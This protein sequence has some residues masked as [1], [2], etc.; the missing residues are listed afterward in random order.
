MS[1]HATPS[2]VYSI[3]LIA[4]SM[5]A[6]VSLF[7]V[8]SSAKSSSPSS[9]SSSAEAKALLNSDWWGNFS[10]TNHCDL[11]GIVCNGA[12]SVIRMEPFLSY[13]NR[14]LENMNWSSLPNLEYIDLSD[15]G[16]TGGIPNEI[17]TL[18]KLTHLNFSLNH[19]ITEGVK[20]YV[21]VSG[22]VKR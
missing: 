13:R 16:L 15:S 14:R 22:E 7:L 4:I 17:G 8:P 19:G 12:G 2:S 5:A 3:V 9:L 6:I 18:S 20:N 11:A 21:A 1:Q 10:S